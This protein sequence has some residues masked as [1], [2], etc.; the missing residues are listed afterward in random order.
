[1]RREYPIDNPAAIEIVTL[2]FLVLAVTLSG[3]SRRQDISEPPPLV[4]LAA[5]TSNDQRA[6]VPIW[7]PTYDNW[8]A[9]LSS[10]PP[11]KNGKL[12]YIDLYVDGDN[13]KCNDEDLNSF[14]IPNDYTRIGDGGLAVNIRGNSQFANGFCRFSGFYMN[15]EVSGSHQGWG[16]TYFGS[17]DMKEV[18]MSGRYC[19]DAR[20]K[21]PDPATAKKNP[22]DRIIKISGI[23]VMTQMTAQGKPY[24]VYYIRYSEES[25]NIARRAACIASICEELI[26]DRSDPTGKKARA[27]FDSHFTDEEKPE[28]LLMKMR[29][30]NQ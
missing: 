29:L 20:Q 3:C 18:L 10:S 23:D 6:L 21:E 17:V 15:K 16:E 9:S 2:I 13:A 7:S 25:S 11:M 26:K 4:D 5:C 14:G 19:L 30:I 8:T 24:R 12:I 1:M 22:N 27:N 28:D